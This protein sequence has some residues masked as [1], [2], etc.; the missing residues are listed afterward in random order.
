MNLDALFQN[1]KNIVSFAKGDVIFNVGDPAE[2]MFIVV[3]GQADVSYN[4][5]IIETVEEGGFF[6]ELAL[7]D[8]RPRSATVVARID[9]KLVPI[10]QRRFTFLIQEHPSFALTIMETMANRLRRQ[11]A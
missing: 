11:T 4:G 7:V 8:S 9:C 5:Q 2:N 6:G 3:K 10:N 1:D